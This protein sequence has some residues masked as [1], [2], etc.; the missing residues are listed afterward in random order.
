MGR[1]RSDLVAVAGSAL[2]LV[3]LIVYL[4]IMGEQQDDPAPWVVG[5]LIVGAAAAG[6]GAVGNP[7]YRRA[8]LV[9]AGVL[10]MA[11]GVLAILSIGLPILVAGAMCLLASL[12]QRSAPNP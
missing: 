5:A 10:L 8:S 9:C 3:M 12:R 4:R 2:A 6:Y 11:L 1:D 7:P